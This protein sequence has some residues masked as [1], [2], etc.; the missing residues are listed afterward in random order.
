MAEMTEVVRGDTTDIH[1]DFAI[2]D[3]LK[4]LLLLIHGVVHSEFRR[5]RHLED[6]SL[7]ALKK[8]P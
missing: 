1:A 7:K 4:D 2:N 6:S 8:K 3:G 5:L